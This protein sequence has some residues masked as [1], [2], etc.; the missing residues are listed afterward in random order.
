MN[1]VSQA[2]VMFL[3]RS[4]PT[5]VRRRTRRVRFVAWVKPVVTPDAESLAASLVAVSTF[6]GAP[7]GYVPFEADAQDGMDSSGDQ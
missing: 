3:V 5:L 1:T 4:P 7:V 2:I 6:Y